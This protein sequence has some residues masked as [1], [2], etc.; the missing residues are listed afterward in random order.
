MS[1]SW[2][3]LGW[4]GWQADTTMTISYGNFSHSCAPSLTITIADTT[5]TISYGNFS[6]PEQL[7]VL[8]LLTY[9]ERP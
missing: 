8:L 9:K 2:E 5:M 3:Y 6:W 1:A 4:E 7:T